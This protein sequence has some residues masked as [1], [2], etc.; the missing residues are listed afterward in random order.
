MKHWKT[1]TILTLS[2][3]VVFLY[4][5]LISTVTNEIILLNSKIDSNG[6][7]EPIEVITILSTQNRTLQQQLTDMTAE[8]ERYKGI[9]EARKQQWEGFSA[10]LEDRYF[11]WNKE[12]V[13]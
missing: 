7:F 5:A 4:C 3:I 6:N 12:A 2:C 1:I 11:K 10:F 9:A 8:Y 13:K